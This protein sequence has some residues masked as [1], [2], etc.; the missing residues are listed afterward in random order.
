MKKHNFIKVPTEWKQFRQ[1]DT[2]MCVTCGAKRFRDTDGKLVGEWHY[3]MP[4]GGWG[5]PA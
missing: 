2:V 5:D 3:Q 1:I 4:G